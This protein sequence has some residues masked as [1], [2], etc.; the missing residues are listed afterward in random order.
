MSAGKGVGELPEERAG[1]PWQDYSGS[2]PGDLGEGA[3]W[4][5]LSWMAALGR[6]RERD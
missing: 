6:G 1:Q 4:G 3:A 2:D 5:G